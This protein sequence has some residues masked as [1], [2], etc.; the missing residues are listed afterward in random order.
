[1]RLIVHGAVPTPAVAVL[2]TWDPLLA[3]HAELLTQLVAHARATGATPMALMLDPPPQV[4]IRGA[5]KLPLFDDAPTRIAQLQRYVAAVGQVMFE[6]G[7]TSRG[8][9][10]F[11]AMVGSAVPLGEF[12]LRPEQTIGPGAGGGLAA[13]IVSTRRRGVRLTRVRAPSSREGSAQVRAALAAGSPAAAAH[14][15]GRW[16][17]LRRPAD[18]RTR[19]AWAPGRYRFVRGADA[20]TPADPDAAET[21]DLRATDDGMAELRWPDP[22]L[23]ALQMVWGP[24]DAAFTTVASA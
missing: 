11:L 8:A 12:W 6:P 15:V 2:G 17:G 22:A 19:M 9:D 14:V 23:D 3:T 20:W 5:H 4:L 13:I 24:G 16:P 10:E 21:L 1:M 18:G 7:D